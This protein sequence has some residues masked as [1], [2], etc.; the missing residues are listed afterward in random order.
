MFKK[1]RKFDNAVFNGFW[2]KLRISD[3]VPKVNVTS[4]VL[5]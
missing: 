3:G 2:H 5:Y 4:Y 1:K